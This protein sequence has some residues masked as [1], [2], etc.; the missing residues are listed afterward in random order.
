M[1]I[2]QEDRASAPFSIFLPPMDY[3]RGKSI[4]IT[5]ASS[6]L[7]LAI[8]S[9]LCDV[10]GCSIIA[11][12]RNVDKLKT[13]INSWPNHVATISYLTVDLE[14]SDNEIAAMV[15]QA[16]SQNGR[17]DVL[18]NCAGIGFRG[19]IADT[20]SNVDRQVMQVDYFGQIAVIKA[21]LKVWQLHENAGG[22]I[23]QISS[24]QAFFGLGERA[25]Y[26]AAK[27]ALAGFID[28]LR[29]ELDSF[30]M[31]SRIRVI[32]VCPGYIR[33]N[34]SLNSITSDGKSYNKQDLSTTDGYDPSYVADELLIRASRGEREIIIAPFK[35]KLLI[36]FR[37]LFHTLVFRLLRLR[38]TGVRESFLETVAKWTFGI[39]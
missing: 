8:V 10:P 31:E 21:L 23:I 11:C 24:V 1:Q 36:L 20:L 32:H 38:L 9:A 7:G 37:A 30:P 27:H 13:Q 16:F 28:S 14:S 19:F 15:T 3:Y 6:G 18:I 17:V 33:T 29:V 5:G 25:P 39:I 26:S 22:D 12:L 4:L 34:H 2:I 35:I